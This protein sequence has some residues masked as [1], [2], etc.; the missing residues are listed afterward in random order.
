VKWSG[1]LSDFDDG[2][3]RTSPVGSFKPN[4]LG[5][6]D[7]GGNVCQW[8]EDEYRASMNDAEAMKKYPVLKSEKAD[9]GTPYRVLR[10]AS[11]DAYGEVGLR[12]SVRRD[13]RPADRID[14]G[15]FR[16]VLVISGG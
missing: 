6:Y 16:C 12:S 1:E 5:L 15:G 4:R 11:W 10:G 8:C 9:D 14:C 13:G 7:M 3:E 2:Y